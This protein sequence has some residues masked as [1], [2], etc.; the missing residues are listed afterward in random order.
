[1]TNLWWD[2][3]LY[4]M[5]LYTF[6]SFSNNY[7]SREKLQCVVKTYLYMVFTNILLYIVKTIWMPLHIF[8]ISKITLVKK[9]T[10]YKNALQAKLYYYNAI[11]TNLD[12]CTMQTKFNYQ[13]DL[14]TKHNYKRSTLLKDCWRQRHHWINLNGKIE[15]YNYEHCVPLWGHLPY[16]SFFFALLHT[17]CICIWLKW[18]AVQLLPITLS[19]TKGIGNIGCMQALHHDFNECATSLC[20][21][22]THVL[23]SK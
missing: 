13:N 19:S 15:P 23:K 1:M 12:Q 14:C 21:R 7:I 17:L 20:I 3:C 18:L 9:T 22:C 8:E 10:H 5:P 4:L 6:F 2:L 11:T 16:R